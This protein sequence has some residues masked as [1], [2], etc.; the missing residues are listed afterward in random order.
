M[1][2]VLEQK[3]HMYTL[4]GWTLVYTPNLGPIATGLVGFDGGFGEPNKHG[5][6]TCIFPTP[7]KDDSGAKKLFVC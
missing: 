2:V 6:V 3:K 7:L 5:H 1:W 4:I